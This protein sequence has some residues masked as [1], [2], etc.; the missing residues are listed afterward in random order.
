[1]FSRRVWRWLG[2]G[3][4][5]SL[6][7][8]LLLL[9]YIAGR[10]WVVDL[11]SRLHPFQSRRDAYERPA[12]SDVL[13]QLRSLRQVEQRD[14]AVGSNWHAWLHYDAGKLPPLSLPP[15]V[16]GVSLTTITLIWGPLEYRDAGEHIYRLVLSGVYEGD[17]PARTSSVQFADGTTTIVGMSPFE[18]GEVKRSRGRN[19]YFYSDFWEGEQFEHK[20]LQSLYGNTESIVWESFDWILV[21]PK[22]ISPQ[23]MLWIYPTK[24]RDVIYYRIQTDA[25]GYL[26]EGVIGVPR[27]DDGAYT[28]KVK[29]L[30]QGVLEQLQLRR[31]RPLIRWGYHFEVVDGRVLVE[32]F[33]IGRP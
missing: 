16:R 14:G 28:L 19:K 29:V 17:A 31:N 24:L 32:R 8:F 4:I 9:A 3:L 18:W 1:M 7:M 33:R 27:R 13:S 23:Q 21:Y 30:N 26:V 5:V 2:F 6:S 10:D 12:L 20:H 22:A 11:D 15:K 25:R